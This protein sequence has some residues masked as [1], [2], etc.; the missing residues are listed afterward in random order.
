LFLLLFIVSSTFLVNPGISIS[1]PSDSVHFLSRSTSL[2][3]G[4]ES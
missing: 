3:R 1:L 2:T 4:I